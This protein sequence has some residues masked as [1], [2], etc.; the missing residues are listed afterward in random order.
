MS[1]IPFIMATMLA[2][3][4]NGATGTTSRLMAQLFGRFLLANIFDLLRDGSTFTST[5]TTQRATVL[6][7]HAREMVASSVGGACRYQH[8]ECSR[9]TLT[10]YTLALAA[11]GLKLHAGLGNRR[12]GTVLRHE[13]NEQTIARR[14]LARH[15]QISRTTL[16]AFE[17]NQSVRLSKIEAYAN[18]IGIELIIRPLTAKTTA[19]APRIRTRKTSR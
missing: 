17:R 7:A 1:P 11:L 8:L 13:R 9:G 3:Q 2:R 10:Y 16:A 15:L 19:T 6:L 4:R 18:A 5:N 12:L 14:E